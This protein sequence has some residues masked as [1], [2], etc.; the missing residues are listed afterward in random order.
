[1]RGF[2][3]KV[4]KVTEMDENIKNE[5]KDL[6]DSEQNEF[7]KERDLDKIAEMIGKA[8]AEELINAG[9]FDRT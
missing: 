3:I 2:Y 8:I 6:L 9:V 5:L 7:D 4:F 1:M